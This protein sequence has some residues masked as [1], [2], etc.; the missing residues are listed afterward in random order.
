MAN[1]KIETTE[2]LEKIVDEQTEMIA[3]QAK[4]ITNLGELVQ[5]MHGRIKVL[6]ALLDHHHELFIQH[7]WAKPRDRNVN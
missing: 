5:G 1:R 3:E 4:T 2:D 7:G 6:T